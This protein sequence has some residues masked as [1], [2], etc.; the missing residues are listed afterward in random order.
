MSDILH[1]TMDYSDML[2]FLRQDSEQWS[3]PLACYTIL[4]TIGPIESNQN[5]QEQIRCELSLS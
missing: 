4:R 3:S 1:L 2:A 5:E